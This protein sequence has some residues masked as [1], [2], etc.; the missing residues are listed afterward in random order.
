HSRAEPVQATGDR[1]APVLL[2]G[3]FRPCGALVHHTHLFPGCPSVPTASSMPRLS[4]NA[5]PVTPDLS[6][7]SASHLNEDASTKHLT[8]NVSPIRRSRAENR[9][10]CARPVAHRS[11]G[12]PNGRAGPGC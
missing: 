11:V 3:A 4:E 10:R 1:A 6:R 9:H 7:V 12:G 5:S 2:R 8:H